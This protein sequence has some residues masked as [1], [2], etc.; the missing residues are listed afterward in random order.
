MVS[1]HLAAPIFSTTM[2]K[3][4][5]LRRPKNS[6]QTALSQY[7]EIKDTWRDFRDRVLSLK[8]ESYFSQGKALATELQTCMQRNQRDINKVVHIVYERATKDLHSYPIAALLFE[9]LGN[10]VED[11]FGGER[12][13]D[14]LQKQIQKSL[15]AL[16]N[17]LGRMEK[18]VGTDVGIVFLLFLL[19]KLENLRKGDGSIF[20]DLLIKLFKQFHV[21]MLGASKWPHSDFSSSVLSAVCVLLHVTN[22][23]ETDSKVKIKI[24]QILG[25]LRSFYISGSLKGL[26]KIQVL[27]TIESLSPRKGGNGCDEFYRQQY[28]TACKKSNYLLDA[29]DTV[30]SDTDVEKNL[31]KE[32]VDKYTISKEEKSSSDRTDSTEALN[33]SNDSSDVFLDD[34]SRINAQHITS[35]KATE[36]NKDNVIDHADELLNSKV[37]CLTKAEDSKDSLMSKTELKN[38]MEDVAKKCIKESISSAEFRK[39]IEV[40]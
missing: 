33:I 29:L 24:K 10:E 35:S 5:P 2:T 38:N 13:L 23:C 40:G 14:E 19:Y 37:S 39:L 21:Y 17:K 34:D 7:A 4:Q 1:A 3:Q 36:K 26:G 27:W 22:T 20:T 6:S 8:R 18:L 16:N 11:S 32:D 30:L 12:I 9:D 15:S 25:L 31:I 28:I